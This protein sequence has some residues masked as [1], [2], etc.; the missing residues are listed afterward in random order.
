[1]KQHFST[2]WIGSTQVRKQRK[3]R[4]KA[5]LHVRNRFLGVH[6]SKELRTKYKTRSITL[7]TGDEVLISR[8]TFAKKKAK[9]LSINAKKS[10]VSLEGITRP[11]KDGSK[12][13]VYL[14]PHALII[15]AINSDD[16]RRMKHLQ[17]ATKTEK[18]HAP[19]TS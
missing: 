2:S 9:V 11:K 1:M 10:R 15:I 18:H 13:Q 6:L 12:T 17:S 19:H 7:R 8:G 16:K 4:Y 5:P 3:Y 14:K